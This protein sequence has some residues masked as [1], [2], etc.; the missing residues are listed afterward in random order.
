MEQYAY[1]FPYSHL[2]NSHAA[3]DIDANMITVNNFFVHWFKKI[4]IKRYRDDLQ[5]L[6]TNNTT[7]IYQYFGAIL[8]HIPKD[9]LKAFEKTLLY[10]KK[11]LF[12]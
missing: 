10:S 2:K 6:P 4:D 12:Y 9:P 7:D 5:I 11:I 3:N 8:K 1:L